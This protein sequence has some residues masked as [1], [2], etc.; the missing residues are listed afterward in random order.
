MPKHDFGIMPKKPVSGKRYDE[1]KPEKYN[2]ISVDDDFL[3]PY[4]EDLRSVKCCWHTLDRPE[5]GLAYDGVTL[6]PPDSIE[7]LI[8]ILENDTHF[9]ELTAMLLRAQREDKFMIHYGI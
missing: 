5:D 7:K 1:Y 2:C 4:L 6:I 8:R 9:S 3:S